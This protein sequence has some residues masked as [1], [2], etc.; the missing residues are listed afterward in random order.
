MALRHKVRDA[1]SLICRYVERHLAR[2]EVKR[3]RF[4]RFQHRV[5]GLTENEWKVLETYCSCREA[6]NVSMQRH[7]WLTSWCSRLQDG[8]HYLPE[9]DGARSGVAVAWEATHNEMVRQK[10]RCDQTVSLLRK[11]ERDLAHTPIYRGLSELTSQGARGP[12]SEDH[13]REQ[14]AASGGCCGEIGGCCSSP[15]GVDPGFPIWF[16]HCT[17]EC[18]CCLE[19][20][21]VDPPVVNVPLLQE[22]H[23]SLNPA[24][25][26]IYSIWYMDALAWGIADFPEA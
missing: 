8:Y 12:L 15:R 16:S 20:N 2:T 5:F 9:E 14:C 22:L 19:R 1:I 23:F 17:S 18:G 13:F 25:D 4:R 3:R 11:A 24:S 7:A 21:G 6:L 10:E 26:D